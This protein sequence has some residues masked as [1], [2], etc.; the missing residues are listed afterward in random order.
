MNSIVLSNSDMQDVY[1]IV[2]K[3]IEKS[4]CQVENIYI[5]QLPSIIQIDLDYKRPNKTDT[6]KIRMNSSYELC[7]PYTSSAIYADMMDFLVDLRYH[8][9][10]GDFDFAFNKEVA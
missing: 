9:I 8:L 1:A 7:V 10:N 3:S 5:K 4:G 6:I 2:Q